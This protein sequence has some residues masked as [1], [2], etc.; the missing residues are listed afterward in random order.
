MSHWNFWIFPLKITLKPLKVSLSL[1]SIFEFSRLFQMF[2]FWRWNMSFETF[3]NDFQT[4]WKTQGE[5][6][7]KL[8]LRASIF[9]GRTINQVRRILSEKVIKVAFLWQYQRFSVLSTRN[10]IQCVNWRSSHV[11]WLKIS[12]DIKN[13]IINVNWS[14]IPLIFYEFSSFQN[15]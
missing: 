15:D 4:L 5:W 6:Q 8:F 13:W 7:S 11:Q 3:L 14:Q 9:V 2:E 12:F 10:R 1:I